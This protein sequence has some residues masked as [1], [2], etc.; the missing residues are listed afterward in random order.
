M[1]YTEI[2]E[3]YR[4]S[5][6]GKSTQREYGRR[7][8][9]TVLKFNSVDVAKRRKRNSKNH[10]QRMYGLTVEQVRTMKAQPCDICGEHKAKMNIDH[11]HKTGRVR[12]VLCNPCNLMLGYLE[13]SEKF[14]N[15]VQ[16][17]L[18]EEA[19]DVAI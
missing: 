12:G 7:Y 1:S 8:Y 11:D 14:G 9:H 4:K 19:V 17:Y 18:H 16:D 10:Y 5:E 3:R 6:K 13:R 2:R 15:R